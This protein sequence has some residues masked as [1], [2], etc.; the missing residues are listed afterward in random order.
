MADI[1][2]DNSNGEHILELVVEE[3]ELELERVKES[4]IKQIKQII[5]CAFC[6]SKELSWKT[7]TVSVCKQIKKNVCEYCG[8]TGHAVSRCTKKIAD[9]EAEIRKRWEENQRLKEEARRQRW[10]ENQRLKEEARRKRWEENQRLKEEARRKRWEQNQR[11]KEEAKIKE[12]LEEEL[13]LERVKESEI[14]REKI[15]EFVSSEIKNGCREI[16]PLMTEKVRKSF[17]ELNKKLNYGDASQLDSQLYGLGG[18]LWREA[19][20]LPKDGD[21]IE[22][23]GKRLIAVNCGIFTFEACEEEDVSHYLDMYDEEE[24]YNDDSISWDEEEE[25]NDDSI[26]RYEADCEIDDLRD[27]HRKFVNYCIKNRCTDSSIEESRTRMDYS[28]ED[29]KRRIRY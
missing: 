16:A 13:E 5:G 26:S 3:E 24:E 14:I 21:E 6:R 15:R 11:L 10:E 9:K 27:E 28:I 19:Y 4:E 8:F 22:V 29:L 17:P 2:I 1:D 20:G 12:E 7:H 23:F 18:S 25:Y